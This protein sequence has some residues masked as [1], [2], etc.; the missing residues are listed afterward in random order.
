MWNQVQTATRD[1]FGAR[2]A[3]NAPNRGNSRQ[4]DD[5]KK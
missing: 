4:P 2:S 3:D 5:G 1:A